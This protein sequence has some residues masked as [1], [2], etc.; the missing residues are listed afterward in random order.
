M[1][2]HKPS[3][4]ADISSSVSVS[5]HNKLDDSSM[6][7]TLAVSHS[8]HSKNLQKKRGRGKKSR[9]H[10]EDNMAEPSEKEKCSSTKKA[11]KLPE[12][13]NMDISAAA[14]AVQLGFEKPHEQIS[15]K[16]TGN[17]K[18]DEVIKQSS[19]IEIIQQLID[20][21]KSCK[22]TCLANLNMHDLAS[23]R[24]EIT[25]LDRQS[26][27]FFIMG[28]LRC[29]A[30][31]VKDAGHRS[32]HARNRYSYRLMNTRICQCCFLAV[33]NIG[34]KY[35]KNLK[36]HFANHGVTFRLHGNHGR[37]PHHA[38]SSSDITDVVEFINRYVSASS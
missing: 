30:V 5:E 6:P 3:K 25:L 14:L 4:Q 7:D 16:S 13:V 32:S 27:D 18:D 17:D 12:D 33:N 1:I 38:I 31:T 21:Q 22:C 34:G 24:M 26:R 23:H 29:G 37:K 2:F 10:A 11:H 8:K 20:Y 19:P 28:L 35:L 36:K 15:I 9:L